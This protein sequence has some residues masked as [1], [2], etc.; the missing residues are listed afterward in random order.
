[1]VTAECRLQEE[2]TCRE[3][4]EEVARADAVARCATEEVIDAAHMARIST[5][6][7]LGIFGLLWPRL[8]MRGGL[9]RPQRTHYI[10]NAK[11]WPGARWRQPRSSGRHRKASRT[12]NLR[13]TLC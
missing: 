7:E 4:A 2:V 3:H 11:G 12:N 5:E 6:R 1:M 13:P 8:N 10:L 9:L